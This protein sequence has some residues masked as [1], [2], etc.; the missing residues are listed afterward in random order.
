MTIKKPGNYKFM[1]SLMQMGSLRANIYKRPDYSNQLK[2]NRLTVTTN[3]Y[4]GGM[5]VTFDENFDNAFVDLT[6]QY[7]V[8][9]Q[10]ALR[11]DN[12]SFYNLTFST[13][14]KFEFFF[15]GKLLLSKTNLQKQSL[16][17]L[18]YYLEKD[19]LY[20]VEIFLQDDSLYQEKKTYTESDR[21]E[22]TE[23]DFYMRNDIRE[24]REDG[25]FKVFESSPYLE[26]RIIMPKN[27]FQVV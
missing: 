19:V 16:S 7:S 17:I 14:L 15:D 10:G 26:T 20:D 11:F 1:S 5:N 13:N 18:D 3:K 9:F 27:M 22:Q 23:Q 12:S 6:Q 21:Q 8:V 4:G 25:Y 24:D 2:E